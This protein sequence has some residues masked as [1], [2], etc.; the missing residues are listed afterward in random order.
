[1]PGLDNQAFA[2]ASNFGQISDT[3]QIEVKSIAPPEAVA[4]TPNVGSGLGPQV[5]SYLYSDDSGYQKITNAYALLNATESWKGSCGVMYIPHNNGLYLRTNDGSGFL[6]PI[7]L[8]QSGTL[9]NSQCSLDAGASSANGSGTKLT[10]NLAITFSPS[11]YNMKNHYM[12]ASDTVHGMDSGWQNMGTWVPSMP[13][14]PS[15]VSVSPSS[16]SGTSQIFTYLY[17]DTSG[18][19]NIYS[20]NTILNSTLNQVSSC[21]TMYLP[22]SHSLYLAQDGG[23]AWLGPVTIGQAGT[24]QNSQCAVD[25]GASSASGSGTNLTVNLAFSFSS[26]FVGM[27]NHYMRAWDAVNNLDSGWQNRGTWT[28]GP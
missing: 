16:G 20:V 9:Q 19:Q 18:Y 26:S 17:S 24:L 13:A 11:F 2:Q 15:A 7:T 14:T 8:G 27:K 4:V 5:F 1:L 21:T 28:T 10:V 6:G 3:G 22:A 25:A 23:S 12:R